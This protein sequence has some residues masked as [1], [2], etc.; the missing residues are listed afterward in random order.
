MKLLHFADLHI[1][2]ETHGRPDPADGISTRLR[3]FLAVFDE[4]VDTALDESVDAVLFAGDA[5]KSRDPTQT[6]QREF[7]RRIRRLSDA[8]VPVFLLVGNHDVPNVRTR[9]SAL[10]IFETLAVPHVTLGDRLATTVL[11]TRAGPL[12]VVGVPWPSVSTMLA[13]EELRGL[14]IVEIDR[15]LERRVAEGIAREA[16]AL[17]PALPAVLVAHI[18]MAGSIVK[19]STEQ[20]MTLGRFPQLQQADLSPEAFDY[21]A[22]GHHHAHQVLRREPPV[23]YA[24]SMQRVDF[25]EEADAKGFVTFELDPAL[26]P[27]RRVPFESVRFREV[28]A[29]RFVTLDLRP[30]S[31]DPTADVLKA[32]ARR[33]IADA[34]VRLRLALTSEQNAALDERALRE[35][36]LPAHTVAAI[37]RE[38]VRPQRRRLRVI[39]PPE[40]LSPLEALEA[41]LAATNEPP[42]RRDTL[43]EYARGLIEETDGQT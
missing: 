33:D 31:P 43:L 13:R 1:G 36:L 29:R 14:S 22:L 32:I 12:Q 34:I 9:A 11:Q 35:A 38:I 3:D 7:A 18:A 17:D 23:V 21:V 28:A 8:G 30:K 16:A 26:P 5:Y 20:F 10:D 24:G 40:S 19:T 2:V 39:V 4:L 42:D 15:E 41:Y 27:G 25:G 6:H 37:S